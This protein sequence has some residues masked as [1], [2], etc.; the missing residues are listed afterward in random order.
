MQRRLYAHA[1]VAVCRIISARFAL[2][3]AL[4]ELQRLHLVLNQALLQLTLEMEVRS[5]WAREPV[6]RPHLPAHPANQLDGFLLWKVFVLHKLLRIQCKSFNR[7]EAMQK[8]K[9]TNTYLTSKSSES[10]GF[11]NSKSATNSRAT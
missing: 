3:V 4:L 11:S 9:Q 8:Q 1:Y 6:I 2:L 5:E 7:G 10:L